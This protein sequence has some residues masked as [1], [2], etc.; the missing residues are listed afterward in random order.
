MAKRKASRTIVG[1]PLTPGLLG[2][3]DALGKLPST[4]GDFKPDG[5]WVNKYRIWT[6]HGYR[7]SG[8]QD[9][10]FVRLKHL[11][12]FGQLFVFT[13]FYSMLPFEQSVYEGPSSGSARSPSR[14]SFASFKNRG[15]FTAQLLVD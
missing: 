9:V 6:C 7:E 14:I 5:N 2:E 8:N 12:P 13:R 1:S 15:V 3:L 4:P 11:N 10:G